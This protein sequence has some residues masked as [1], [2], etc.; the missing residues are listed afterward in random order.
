MMGFDDVLQ[1][2]GLLVI[3]IPAG[4]F[5]LLV[6]GLAA[7]RRSFGVTELYIRVLLAVFEVSTLFLSYAYCY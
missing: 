7:I 6:I 1:W 3:V 4:L 5:Y 2:L